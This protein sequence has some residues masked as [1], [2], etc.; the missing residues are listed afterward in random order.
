MIQVAKRNQASTTPT[1]WHAHLL[2][3]Y[4]LGGSRNEPDPIGRIDLLQVG[5]TS[6]AGKT[7]I[8]N[9][10]STQ[11]TVMDVLALCDQMILEDPVSV[12]FADAVKSRCKASR[13]FSVSEL[14]AH[15]KALT[16]EEAP[17]PTAKKWTE[18]LL[19]EGRLSVPEVAT[20]VGV[21]KRTIYNV[22][23][24]RN[25]QANT[26]ARIRRLG[27]VLRPVLESRDAPLV[28]SWL[29]GGKP[30]PADCASAEQWLE[31]ELAVATTTAPLRSTGEVV[32][33]THEE[34]QSPSVR[35]AVLTAFSTPATRSNEVRRRR[36][37]EDTG[38]SELDDPEEAA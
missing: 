15:A 17:A 4:L 20:L 23:S 14:I 19:A 36:T 21:G 6:S 9:D 35:H 34:R 18:R 33:D 26:E 1:A 2:G 16:N 32:S 3:S 11:C 24:G 31:L 13:T 12:T 30:S 8:L 37:R 7:Y 22:L 29:F 38:I 25:V 27:E 5:V 28:R 10:L